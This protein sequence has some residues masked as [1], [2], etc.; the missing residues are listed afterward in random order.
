[1]EKNLNRWNNEYMK[2]AEVNEQEVPK[3]SKSIEVLDLLISYSWEYK[4]D[5]EQNLKN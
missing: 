1:M 5:K 3:I 4:E 2:R